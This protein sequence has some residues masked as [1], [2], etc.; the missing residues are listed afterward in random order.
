MASTL[1]PQCAVSGAIYIYGVSEA[2]GAIGDS[3]E[4]MVQADRHVL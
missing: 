1:A 3:Q 4:R 2:H